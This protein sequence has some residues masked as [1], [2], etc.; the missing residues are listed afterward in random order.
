MKIVVLD[1]L[2]LVDIILS[3]GFDFNFD[4]ILLFETTGLVFISVSV[5]SL[6]FNKLSFVLTVDATQKKSEPNILYSNI[7]KTL[8]SV[9]ILSRVLD[10]KSFKVKTQTPK[11]SDV[12]TYLSWCCVLNF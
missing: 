9:I 2:D 5:V 12:S 10:K 1:F 11:G 7:F 3:R 4:L 8:P 6:N